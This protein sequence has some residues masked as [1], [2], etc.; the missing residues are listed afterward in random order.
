MTLSGINCD[1]TWLTHSCASLCVCALLHLAV[2]IGGVDAGSEDVEQR[3]DQTF[4][5]PQLTPRLFPCWAQVSDTHTHTQKETH[6]NSDSGAVCGFP[7]WVAS[8]L[9]GYSKEGSWSSNRNLQLL[10]MES[11]HEKTAQ[12]QQRNP[13]MHF[14]T[15]NLQPHTSLSEAKCP[16]LACTRCFPTALQS[17]RVWDTSCSFLL[18]G[19]HLD[20]KSPLSSFEVLC[21]VNKSTTKRSIASLRPDSWCYLTGTVSPLLTTETHER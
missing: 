19:A 4:T 21:L 20:W 13:T 9:P 7:H 8:N 3:V 5:A 16:R 15:I 18:Q 14:H 12:Q 6:I 11:Y 1:K 10:L 2:V 17:C